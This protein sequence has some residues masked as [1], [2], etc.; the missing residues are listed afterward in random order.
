MVRNVPSPCSVMGFTGLEI[1]GKL[2]SIIL[3]EKLVTC[4]KTMKIFAKNIN[5]QGGFSGSWQK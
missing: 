4:A 1:T 3:P 2:A 5:V